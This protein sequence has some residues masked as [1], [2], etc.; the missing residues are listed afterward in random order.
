MGYENSTTA[1]LKNAR[2]SKL[3]L[4][5][6]HTPSS[7]KTNHYCCAQHKKWLD[8]SRWSQKLHFLFMQIFFQVNSLYG[9]QCMTFFLTNNIFP[10]IVERCR[11]RFCVTSKVRTNY[12]FPVIHGKLVLCHLSAFSSSWQLTSVKIWHQHGGHFWGSWATVNKKVKNFR[13]PKKY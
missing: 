13:R 5:S 3:T 11:V 8:S 10:A 4:L 9:C 2:F 1:I 6:F 12:R 7:W